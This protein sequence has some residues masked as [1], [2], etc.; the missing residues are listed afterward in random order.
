MLAIDTSGVVP[1]VVTSADFAGQTF[2]P[3]AGIP[4]QPTSLPVLSQPLQV[5]ANPTPV[6]TQG[7]VNSLKVR[8][9]KPTE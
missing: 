4:A 9:Y 8:D 1:V 3:T 6:I 5:I 2:Y 7:Q